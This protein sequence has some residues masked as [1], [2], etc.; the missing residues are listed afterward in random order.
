MISPR[1]LLQQIP[2]SVAANRTVVQGR[3]ELIRVEI[4]RRDQ[5]LTTTIAT[6]QQEINLRDDLLKTLS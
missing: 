6:M 2:M 1:D 4:T 3:D 5:L